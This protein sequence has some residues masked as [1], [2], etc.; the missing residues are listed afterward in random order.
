MLPEGEIVSWCEHSSMDT[1]FPSNNYICV[2]FMLCTV[3]KLMF[4][5]LEVKSS[6]SR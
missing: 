2:E 4:H 5:C 1:F 3:Y 6:D